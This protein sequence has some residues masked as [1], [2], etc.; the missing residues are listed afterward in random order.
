MSGLCR[1]IF[2]I[3]VRAT[4]REPS[5]LSPHDFAQA[6]PAFMPPENQ[7]SLHGLY[8]AL[9]QEFVPDL[10]SYFTAFKN[11]FLFKR[12]PRFLPKSPAG[13][14]RIIF[15]DDVGHHTVPGGEAPCSSFRETTRMKTGSINQPY[16][17][18]IRGVDRLYSRK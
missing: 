8:G 13:T 15:T 1:V 14:F 16:R 9:F 6:Q 2:Q 18:F 17:V 5:K 11:T 4:I 10:N 7:N 3:I 12:L